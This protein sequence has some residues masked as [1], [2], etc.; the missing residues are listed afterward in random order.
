MPLIL[1]EP[2]KEPSKRIKKRIDKLIANSENVKLWVG[3]NMVSMFFFIYLFHK[4][5]N[6]CAIPD[7]A[8][9]NFQYGITL[10]IIEYTAEQEQIYIEDL[11]REI[12]HFSNCIERS[13]SI[14]IL[15]LFLDFKDNSLMHQN[16]IIYRKASHIIEHFEPHGDYFRTLDEPD[17]KNKIIHK[18]ITQF[19]TILNQ[20]LAIHNIIPVRLIRSNQLCPYHGFQVLDDIVKSSKLP[21]EEAGYCVIWSMFFAELVLKNPTISSE[22]LIRDVLIS[23]RRQKNKTYMLSIARGY[24][25]LVYEKIDKYFKNIPGMPD[26]TADSIHNA[27]LRDETSGSALNTQTK[28]VIN[29]AAYL[30]KNM[31]RDL[32][33]YPNY[34]ID[35]YMQNNKTHLEEVIDD[36]NN[37]DLA[38]F[39]KKKIS[40]IETM[41]KDKNPKSQLN[42]LFDVS[43]VSS[44]GSSSS[45]KT[46]SR[47]PSKTAKRKISSPTSPHQSRRKFTKRRFEL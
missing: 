41:A 40:V 25:N 14:V 29:E 33:Q 43:P 16:I 8:M 11:K 26:I 32:L 10:D 7:E 18:R 46:P 21:I 39:L 45:Q 9:Y 34:T 5:K 44:I 20:K 12:M 38:N 28:R 42:T 23:F 4:Y 30:Y 1:P 13:K 3:S 37:I 17:E 2:Y 6:Y 31:H 15:P 22:D 27:V 47:S 36:P 19:L 35:A 24:V